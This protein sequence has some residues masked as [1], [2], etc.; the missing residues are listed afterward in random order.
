[1]C[2]VSRAGAT[3]GQGDGDLDKTMSTLIERWLAALSPSCREVARL[4]SESLDRPLSGRERLAMRLHFAI[5][6]LCR[7][8]A[9]QTALLHTELRRH[10]DL[11]TSCRDDC[12]PEE[13]KR[14]LKEA[15]RRDGA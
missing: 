9:R 3:K 10:G 6:Y 8:Y 15:C 4:A 11:F 13:D 5:C 14:R 2:K 1:M 12:L 7:R